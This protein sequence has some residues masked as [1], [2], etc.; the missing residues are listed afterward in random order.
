MLEVYCR[1]RGEQ[2]SVVATSVGFQ[3]IFLFI[4]LHSFIKY[5]NFYVITLEHAVVLKLLGLLP[6]HLL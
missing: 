2:A 6:V 5:L 3:L 4:L 1:E